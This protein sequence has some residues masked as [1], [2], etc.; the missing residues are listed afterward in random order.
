MKD[1]KLKGKSF[2]DVENNPL[3]T[4]PPALVAAIKRLS[5]AMNFD[6]RSWT[7]DSRS[8]RLK[9]NGP[10]RSFIARKEKHATGLVSPIIA[11]A[12]HPDASCAESRSLAETGAGTIDLR[13]GNPGDGQ[14]VADQRL[15]VADG[16]T[17]VGRI[18]THYSEYVF[19]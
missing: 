9:R 18:H 2:F 6:D 1:G 19:F 5:T 16:S 12:G 7:R 3:I 13:A 15:V 10:G 4:S 14:V 11:P 8:Q 17:G